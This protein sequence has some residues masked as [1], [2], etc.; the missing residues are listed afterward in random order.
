M[1]YEIC[2]EVRGHNNLES[3]YAG[4]SGKNLFGRGCEYFNDFWKK[5][6]N[7]PLLK[8]IVEKHQGD[9]K[10]V[11]MF[12]HFSMKLTSVFAKPQRRK[13]NEGVRISHLDPNTRM[14]SKDEF[15]Q[16]TNIFIQPVRGV[17]V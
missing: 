5:R 3:K 4:E 10:G 7:K 12:S 16:D 9:T 8:H 1:G 17:G 14:N 11:P 6:V 15:L 13:A 2:C